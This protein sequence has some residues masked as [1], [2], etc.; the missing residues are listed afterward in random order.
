MKLIFKTLILL[1]IS[2]CA[3]A[4]PDS[5][6]ASSN[7]LTKQ[8]RMLVVNFPRVFTKK[9]IINIEKTNAGYSKVSFTNASGTYSEA[10]I[11]DKNPMLLTETDEE[12]PVEKLPAPVLAAPKNNGYKNDVKKAFLV[13]TPAGGKLY[14]LDLFKDKD[15]D[16][17]LYVD[18]NGNKQNWPVK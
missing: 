9:N 15:M 17:T 8:K 2:V 13:S 6:T 18:A 5:D 1:G 16:T 3:A 12:V 7:E 10:F 11:S 14:R 4:Q